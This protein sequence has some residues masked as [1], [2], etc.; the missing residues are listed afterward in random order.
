MDSRRTQFRDSIQ[1]W[2]RNIDVISN[3]QAEPSPFLKFFYGGWLETYDPFGGEEYRKQMVVDDKAVVHLLF[4]DTHTLILTLDVTERE[5]LDL[6][7]Q[8]H[9][10][11]LRSTPQSCVFPGWPIYKASSED[12][13]TQA[14]NLET[15]Q[16][17]M[18]FP[19]LPELQISVLREALTLNHGWS[20]Q[21][22]AKYVEL[23]SRYNQ[24]VVDVVTNLVRERR[25][26]VVASDEFDST[27]EAQSLTS[28]V[29]SRQAGPLQQR[30]NRRNLNEGFRSLVKSFQ[31]R[32]S[33][34]FVTK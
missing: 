29:P 25:V 23:S 32:A 9:A 33:R 1:L 12:K 11:F 16:T 21:R 4:E 3:S 31:R 7:Q 15:P 13:A 10:A 22:K 2:Q 24:P 18:C 17:F 34:I 8:T 6:T 27:S 28:R 20:P 5:E 19:R 14:A 30:S 26:A